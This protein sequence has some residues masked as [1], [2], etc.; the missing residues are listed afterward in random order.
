VE[1][2]R[3][4]V[5]ELLE[6]NAGLQEV[7]AAKDHQIASQERR[8][9]ELERRLG[10]DSSTSSRPPSS[11]SPYRKPARRSSRKSSGRRPGKQPGDRG[12]TMPLVDDPDETIT[13]DPGCCG[14]CGAS[15]AGAPVL[16][17][18]RRQVVQVSPPPP[19][20]TEYTGP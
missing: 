13:C 4:L 18:Q 3:A 17:V 19:R 10:V 7:I 16:G 1:E 9:A 6:A 14:G 20:V 2:L 5:M 12:T 15:L 11:D 8:I